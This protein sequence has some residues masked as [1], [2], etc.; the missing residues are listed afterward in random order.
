MLRNVQGGLAKGD[1]EGSNKSACVVMEKITIH[2]FTNVVRGID[3]RV[4]VQ[5]L[6][7]KLVKAVV[8]RGAR[9]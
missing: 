9:R 3:A 8:G 2:L 6:R 5:V 4:R 7:L 1:R